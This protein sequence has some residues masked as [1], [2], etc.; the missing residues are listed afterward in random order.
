LAK[1]FGARVHLIQVVNTGG[2]SIALGLNAASGGMSDPTAI[3]GRVDARVEVAKGYLLAVAEQ[4]DADG[5]SADYAIYDGPVGNDIIE[6][7]ARVSADLIVMSSHGHSGW[8][9]FVFGSVADH[10]VRNS[11]MPVLIVRNPNER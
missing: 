4:L 3:T 5:I 9:R 1:R 11:P 6:G 7:A 8:R 10:V 2:A